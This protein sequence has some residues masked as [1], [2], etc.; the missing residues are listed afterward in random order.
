M[1]RSGVTVPRSVAKWCGRACAPRFRLLCLV[2][3]L[4][5]AASVGAFQEGGHYYSL[6]A[7]FSQAKAHAR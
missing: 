4:I 6:L 3:G 2:L 7:V 5:V 1:S